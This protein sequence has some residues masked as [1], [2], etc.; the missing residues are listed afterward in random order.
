MAS[1]G[2]WLIKRMA[3]PPAN[4][5]TDIV[6]GKV[7]AVGPLQVQL[8]NNMILPNSLLMLGRHVG[9]YKVKVT[10]PDRAVTSINFDGKTYAV[11]DKVRTEVV[12]IDESLKVGDGVAMIRADGGQSFYIFEKLGGDV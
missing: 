10:Y 3:S 1:T 9:K 11:D 6:F 2:D 4:T 7:I 12:T 8:S 5:T